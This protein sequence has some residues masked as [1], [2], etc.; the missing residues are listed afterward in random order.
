MTASKFPGK[1]NTVVKTHSGLSPPHPICQ[2]ILSHFTFIWNSATLT[3]STTGSGPRCYPLFPESLPHPRC[4]SSCSAASPSHQSSQVDQV[5]RSSMKSHSGSCIIKASKV[6]H[7]PAPSPFGPFAHL[8]SFTLLQTASGAVLHTGL[9]SL[10][11]VPLLSTT[12]PFPAMLF[13]WIST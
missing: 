11:L 10:T 5:S 13:P 3:S 8:L 6:L 1:T 4:Y 2:E 12:P 9:L 7:D